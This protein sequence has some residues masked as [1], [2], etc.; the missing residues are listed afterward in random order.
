VAVDVP[1]GIT[2]IVVA[3][4]FLP[5]IAARSGRF[6]ILGGFANLN[7]SELYLVG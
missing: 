6:D 1:I 7:A 2:T 3:P 5:K 4:R